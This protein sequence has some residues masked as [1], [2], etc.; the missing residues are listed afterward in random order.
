[1]IPE[2]TVGLVNYNAAKHLAACIN[3]V[4]ELEGI[5]VHLSIVDNDSTDGSREWLRSQARI[6]QLILNPMNVGFGRA[7]NQ[8]IS[9]TSSK[10]Y[11]ALNPDVTLKPDYATRVIEAIDASESFG[12]ATGKIMLMGSDRAPTA[13][14]YSVGHALLRDGYAFNIGTHDMDVAQFDDGREVFGANAAAVVYKRDMLED[15][16]DETGA[17][18]DDHMFLFYEDVD[19]DWR[20]RLLGWRCLYVPRAIAHHIGAYA[21]G[22]RDSNLATQ[23]LANRYRSVLKNAFLI[24][25]LLR[26]L[27]LYTLHALLRFV[28]FRSG[29]AKMLEPLRPHDLLRIAGQRREMSRRRRITRREMLQWFEWSA[30]QPGAE[31]AGLRLRASRVRSQLGD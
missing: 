4:R 28:Y 11:L 23:G 12:W 13:K 16:R 31:R 15:I 2:V 19:L 1:M 18:F 30:R 9:M 26:N 14:I 3:S 5:D 29:G 8:V 25:L 10:Y 24:D 17:Y 6:D 22:D 7:H 27:P 20:A 21:V